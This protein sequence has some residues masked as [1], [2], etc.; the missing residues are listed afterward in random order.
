MSILEPEHLS[1]DAQELALARRQIEPSKK[2]TK[3][4]HIAASEMLGR[5]AASIIGSRK[6]AL[7]CLILKDERLNLIVGPGKVFLIP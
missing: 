1:V 6:I 3:L 4:T 5:I 2:Q 7:S